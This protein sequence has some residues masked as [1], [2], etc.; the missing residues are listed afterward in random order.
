MAQP[1]LYRRSEKNRYLCSAIVSE[2]SEIHEAFTTVAETL[3]DVNQLNSFLLGES[4]DPFVGLCFH[5]QQRRLAYLR[6]E[7][8]PMDQQRLIV[9]I[10]LA[11]NRRC[12]S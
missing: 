6:I 2:M 12:V 4:P 5:L 8:A 7:S 3:F 10:H 1:G 9:A 11:V